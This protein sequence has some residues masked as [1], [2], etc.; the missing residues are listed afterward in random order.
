MYE[1]LITQLA[2]HG[3][4]VVGINSVFIHGD[5]ALPGNRIVSIVAPK[6]LD[7]VSDKTIPALEQDIAF[8]YNSWNQTT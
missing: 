8:V 3:Y 4:F 5:I 6:N 2:S 7:V 1:N